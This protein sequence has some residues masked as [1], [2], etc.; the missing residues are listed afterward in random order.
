MLPW[1]W[2]HEEVPCASQMSASEPWLNQPHPST[3]VSWFVSPLS[4]CTSVHRSERAAWRG[5]P[6]LRESQRSVSEGAEL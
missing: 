1:R 4:R 3:R 5:P 6:G 2:L